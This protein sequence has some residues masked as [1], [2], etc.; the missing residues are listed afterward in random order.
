M[1]I[2]HRLATVRRADEMLVVERGVIVQRG[3]ERELLVAD[4]PFRR[5]AREL[6]M[7]ANA[8]PRSL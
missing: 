7:P 1:I 2:A 4:G 3:A 6:A 5:L 8:R